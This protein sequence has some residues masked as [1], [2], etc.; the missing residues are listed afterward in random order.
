LI[1]HGRYVCQARRRAARLAYVASVKD[2]PMVGVVAKLLGRELEQLSLD[3]FR[4]FARR[5]SRTIG[6]A[7]Y[8]G[9]DRDGWLTKG[10]VEHHI[11]ALA[12][13]ARQ[14][15]QRFSLSGNFA[16]VLA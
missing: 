8:V 12:T 3:L 2:Q 15:H 13:H 14:S 9:V 5:E 7:E 16:A 4:S 6:D 10:H 1:L 11:G